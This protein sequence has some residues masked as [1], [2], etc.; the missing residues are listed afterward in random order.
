MK[1]LAQH[2]LHDKKKSC[3]ISRPKDSPKQ[4]YLKSTNIG[5]C[6]GKFFTAANFD[7]LSKIELFFI[8]H[9][10]FGKKHIYFNKI[11][12]KIQGQKI[13]LK[14]KDINNLPTCV[15]VGNNGGKPFHCYQL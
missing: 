12:K 9:E 2:D 4:S 15:V 11:K 8:F 13:D 7:S 1:F 6:C 10:I 3:K 5:S 14:K